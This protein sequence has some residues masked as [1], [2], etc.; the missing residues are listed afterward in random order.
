MKTD[1][2]I[3][4]IIRPPHR[5]LELLRDLVH[6]HTGLYFDDSKIDS[7]L[8]KISPLIAERASGSV[9]DFYFILKDDSGST[10]EWPR[11]FDALTVQESYF[12][13]EM[14]QIRALVVVI[15]PQYFRAHPDETLNIWSAACAAGCEPLTIAMALNEAAWFDRAK[16]HIHASDA[17]PRAIEAARKGMYREHS[18]RRLP[19]ALREKYFVRNIG[20]FSEGGQ[21][22][23]N[24]DAGLSRVSSE[25]HSRVHWKTANLMSEG[26]LA[27]ASIA[28]PVIFCRNVFIYFSEF[29]TG[30]TLRALARKMP[31][32]GYLFLGMAE[33]LMKEMADFEPGEIGDAFVHIRS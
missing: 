19:P 13:R 5:G 8:G 6:E 15:V 12:W 18:F 4:P 26:D 16:I 25:L 32:P 14:E 17:S 2:T 29:A 24:G 11:V 23:R 28:S 1:T 22:R 10:D 20:T 21:G 7:F 9:M 31:R 30:K 27:L 33:S 3:D